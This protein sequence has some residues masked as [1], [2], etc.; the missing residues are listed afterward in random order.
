MQPDPISWPSG[1]KLGPGGRNP[2][3][4]P[5]GNIHSERPP[6]PVPHP[7]RSGDQSPTGPRM[8]HSGE[9]SGIDEPKGSS[10]EPDSLP[11]GPSNPMPH[12]WPVEPEER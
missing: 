5:G 3:Q 6:S 4:T 7:D 8:P 10:S 1:P 11:G 9:D 2:E 12:V